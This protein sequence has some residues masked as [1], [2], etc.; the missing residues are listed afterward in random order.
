MAIFG[1]SKF[2]LV[3]LGK[4]VRKNVEQ[5]FQIYTSLF[6][7]S[8]QKKCEMAILAIP[9]LYQSFWKKLA[10]KI[11]TGHF[12]LFSIYTSLF[13]ISCQKNLEW[14]FQIYTCLLGKNC[15]KKFKMAIFGHSKF[16]PVFLGKAVGKIVEWPFLAILNL[17]Q[18]FL[19]KCYH[20]QECL[21]CN[22]VLII[23][24]A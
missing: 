3:F 9:D 15:Q 11:Q 14:Q 22:G 7:K 12:W 2:V 23:S 5:P 6:G 13:G 10:E 1:H 18:F 4:V 16:I 17:C 24:E 21:R 8:C 20:N 19:G